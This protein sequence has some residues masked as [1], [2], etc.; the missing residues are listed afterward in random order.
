MK[1]I[2]LVMGLLILSACHTEKKPVGAIT[3]ENDYN[4]FLTAEAPTT[5]SK[6]FEIW[7][8]KIKPDSM[9]LTSFG[10]VASEYNRYFKSTGDIQYLKKAAQAL[11]RA[12]TIAAVGKSNYYRALAR[13]YIAQ[14]RF[15]E[16]LEW[17]VKAHNLGSGLKESEQLLFDVHMELGNYTEA[18]SY[19]KKIRNMSDFGYLIRL[20][21]WSDHKGDLTKA[22]GFMEIAKRIAETSKNKELILWSYTN[23]A[24]YY[25][26]AGRIKKS[27]DHYLKSLQLD[28]KNAYAKKGIAWIVFSYERNATEALRILDA[29]THQN[30]S[31]D[32]W[33]LKAEIAEFLEDNQKK[34]SYLEQFDREV[35]NPSYGDMYNGHTV[36]L[37]QE[38]PDTTDKALHLAMKE[39]QNRATPQTYDMLAYSYLKRGDKN[40]AMEIAE[41][42][43]AGQ[44]QEPEILYHL[45]EIYKENGVTE[46]VADLK[47]ALQQAI[48]ELGPLMEQRISE[49]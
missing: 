23:L 12:V 40:K 39:V 14:H 8:S 30:Q 20:A 36:A 38:R 44:T 31:P 13:N 3:N 25:G 5:T 45:A 32:Y 7:N 27:Y 22:I 17:A 21:K 29:V 1:F 35:G 28:P 24:D 16:A 26:H 4:K 49:L 19:L 41:K 2:T 18:E 47:E 10:I 6:Y 33:L 42:H 34:D 37:L 9:Q 46:K 48:Y 15:K 11:Q 43:V